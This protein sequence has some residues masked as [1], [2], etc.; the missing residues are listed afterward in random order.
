M[1]CA[2]QDGEHDQRAA[3][4]QAGCDRRGALGQHLHRAGDRMNLQRQIRQ[5]ADEHERRDEQ[6]GGAPGKA[7]GEQIG[8]RGELVFVHQA[9]QGHEQHGRQQEGNGDA[10]IDGQEVEAGI[11]READ[12]AVIR[13]GTGVHAERQRH[14]DRMARQPRRQPAVFGQPG[15]QE[16]QR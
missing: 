10:E 3:E 14:R 11:L 4:G 1:A 13:P 6:P 8:Q 9:Q 5:D 16:Q 15:H 2:E 12:T 7:E